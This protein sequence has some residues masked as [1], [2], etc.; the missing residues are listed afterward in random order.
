M[1]VYHKLKELTMKIKIFIFTFIL[2]V[3]GIFPVNTKANSEN[4][5][6]ESVIPALP[7]IKSSN[8]VLMD[9]DS[10][11]VLYSKNPDLKCFPASTTKLLTGLLTVENT[12]PT[13]KITF[14]KKA[15]NSIEPGDANASISVGETLTID[16]ALHCLLLRS[17]NEVAYG[18]AEYIGGDVQSFATLMNNKLEEIGAV[19]SHFISP[20]GLHNTLHYTTPYDMALIARECFNNKTLMKVLG[21]SDLYVIEPTNKSK[22]TRY[23]KPRFQMLT[24]GE[25][26]YKYCVGGKTGF[27]DEAGNCVVAFAQKDDL[28]L[29]CVVLNSTE[30]DR[31]LDSTALFNYYFNNFKKLYIDSGNSNIS[32]VDIEIL[33]LLDNIDSSSDIS[34]AFEENAYLLVPAEANL[35][36]LTCIVTY[37]DNLAYKGKEGGFACINYFYKS[38]DVGSATLYVNDSKNSSLQNNSGVPA[39]DYSIDQGTKEKVHY[40]NILY[41]LY[42]VGG[43]AVF[44]LLIMLLTKNSRKKNRRNKKLHF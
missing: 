36:D 24:G 26:A 21:Y 43:I 32:N 5:T 42:S 35:S 39:L 12:V 44:V 9:A 11:E 2:I 38:L 14:S 23:Y 19:N 40:I 1:E 41:I 17:A 16:Q 31:Y 6:E 10:G 7:N 22:F 18:L 29:I 27:T 37:S 13:A 20:S 33:N 28:R 3:A 34:I 8:I 15:V 4:N 30:E 25:Y